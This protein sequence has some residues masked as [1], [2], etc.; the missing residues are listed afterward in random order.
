MRRGGVKAGRDVARVLEIGGDPLGTEIG[1]VEMNGPRTNVVR[2]WI[3][4]V[5]F[6]EQAIDLSFHGLVLLGFSRTR[7]AARRLDD[8]CI[9]DQ[10][11]DMLEVVL[12]K[13][14]HD[15][16]AQAGKREACCG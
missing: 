2:R 10:V 12:P 9:D 5:D 14:G 11:S 3:S 4:A 1:R 13:V 6:L 8:R 15:V 16:V 7:G